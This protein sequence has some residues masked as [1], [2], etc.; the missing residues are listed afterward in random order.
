MDVQEP[1]F[2]LRLFL[3]KDYY[4]Y[5]G[6]EYATEVVIIAEKL[7]LNNLKGIKNNLGEAQS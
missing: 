1:A 2:S 5:K 4:G 3:T 6:K 7:P